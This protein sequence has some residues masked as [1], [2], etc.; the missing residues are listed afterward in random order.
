MI[1]LHVTAPRLLKRTLSGV[2]AKRSLDAGDVT[3]IWDATPPSDPNV[4]TG[5]PVPTV[6]NA[7]VRALVHAVSANAVG[8]QGMEFKAGDALL[9]FPGGVDVTGKAALR[10]RLPDGCIYGQANTGRGVSRFRDTT[11][12]G[13]DIAYTMHVRLRPDS[14]PVAG[15]P[16]GEIRY[17][18]GAESVRLYEFDAEG[19]WCP[20][21]RLTGTR[22]ALD[23]TAAGLCTVR[24]GGTV[25]LTASASG[26]RVKVLTNTLASTFPRLDFFYAGTRRA[27]LLRDGTLGA[28]GFA[29]LAAPPA[30]SMQVQNGVNLFAVGPAGVSAAGI[31]DE[32]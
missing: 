15:T 17:V 20:D 9:T 19:L 10:Y 24:F 2:L 31:S 13:E 32:L 18:T 4:E 23:F 22:A 16:L 6:M 3:L 27:T 8:R 30:A 21:V 29:D 1:S 25:A 12:G 28:T 14:G 5:A 11:L 7:T 26:L